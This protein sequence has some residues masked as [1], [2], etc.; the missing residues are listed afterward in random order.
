MSSQSIRA[1]D[2]GRGRAA[3]AR[4]VEVPGPDVPFAVLAHRRADRRAL[5]DAHPEGEDGGRLPRPYLQR[6][7]ER[8]E[9]GDHHDL[10]DRAESAGIDHDRDLGLV[11]GDRR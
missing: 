9:I 3:A 11:L 10:V 1:L 6:E 5:L 2:V 7:R 4:G 8:A